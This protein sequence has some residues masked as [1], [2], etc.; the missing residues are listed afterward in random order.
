M[1]VEL[2]G[3]FGRQCYAV[4][5]LGVILVS[6]S[7]VRYLFEDDELIDH[8]KERTTP[9]LRAIHGPPIRSSKSFC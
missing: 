2:L 3:R 4:L 9:S 1:V 6:A 7:V 5:C 8:P